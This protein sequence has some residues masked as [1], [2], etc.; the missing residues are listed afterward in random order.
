MQA[1]LHCRYVLSLLGGTFCPP[2][3]PNI[4]SPWPSSAALALVPLLM[5]VSRDSDKRMVQIHN[6][7]LITVHTQEL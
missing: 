7:Y 2:T 3:P 1:A 6:N 4:L 5:F